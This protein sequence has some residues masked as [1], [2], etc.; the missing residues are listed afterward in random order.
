[1][2]QRLFVLWPMPMLYALLGMIN[3]TPKSLIIIGGQPISND[4]F[5]N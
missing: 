3:S 2:V 1:M 4:W 5:G